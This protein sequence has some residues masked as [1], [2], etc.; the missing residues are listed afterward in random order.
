MRIFGLYCLG[1]VLLLAPISTLAGIK[2]VELMPGDLIFSMDTQ[3]GADHVGVFSEIGSDGRPYVFHSVTG[4]YQSLIK[5]VLKPIDTHYLV[6]RNNNIALAFSAHYRM[7]RWAEQRVPYDSDAA[8]FIQNLEDDARFG[9][10]AANRLRAQY[11]YARSMSI[12]RFYRRIKYAARRNFPVL[13][14]SDEL[15]SSG[16]GFRCAE[17]TI[18]AYQIQELSELVRCVG[19]PKVEGYPGHWVSDKY[20]DEKDLTGPDAGG[21]V[22]PS[23]EFLDYQRG[24]R[25]IG[26]YETAQPRKKF[27][28]TH[29][30]FKPSIHYWDFEKNPSIEAFAR[31]F[32]TSLPIDSKVSS[33]SVLLFHVGHDLA[34][35]QLMDRLEMGSEKPFSEAEKNFWRD[36]VKSQIREVGLYRDLVLDRVRAHSRGAIAESPDTGSVSPELKVQG[37]PEFKPIRLLTEVSEIALDCPIDLAREFGPKCAG[38]GGGAGGGGGGAGAF[39]GASEKA[40]SSSH[41][42]SASPGFD[43][44]GGE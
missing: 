1:L 12:P 32:D 3:G 39:D 33:P 40:R 10:G 29:I 16:R 14:K 37:D 6:F 20:S 31:T 26:E 30:R 13:P 43:F 8:A 28:E 11:D 9:K 21:S 36:Q 42:I 15:G 27:T 2:V 24:L 22:P 19:D 35:W 23:V 4:K 41:S 7:R 34:H 44:F 18:L 38:A 17:S 25:E 5:G